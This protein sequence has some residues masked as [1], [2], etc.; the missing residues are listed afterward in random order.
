[1]KITETQFKNALSAMAQSQV[2]YPLADGE[3]EL[4]T[5]FLIDWFII[6]AQDAVDFGVLKT[7]HFH[8]YSDIRIMEKEWFVEEI[9]R[10]PFRNALKSIGIEIE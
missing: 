5:D 2:S 1:M 8:S 4:V 6:D 7:P 3:T 9:L 10:D